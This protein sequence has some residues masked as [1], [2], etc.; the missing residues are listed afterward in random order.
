MPTPEKKFIQR[1][2]CESNK[3]EEEK[4]IEIDD[5]LIEEISEVECIDKAEKLWLKCVITP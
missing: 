3:E 4:E 5:L 1:K 2:E